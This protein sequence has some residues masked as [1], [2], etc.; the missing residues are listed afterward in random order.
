MIS[1]AN[2]RILVVA[3][4]PDDEVLGC[5]GTLAKSIA[6]GAEAS[7][8]LLGEGPTSRSN[9]SE[10]QAQSEAIRCAKAAAESLKIKTLSFGSLPDNQF[11]TVPLLNIVQQIEH[12]VEQIQ[13]DIVFTHHYGD[14]NIDHSLTHRATL[15]ALRPLPTTKPV[16]IL[17]FEVLSSTE[18]T[19]PNSLP[20]FTPNLYVDISQHLDAKKQALNEYAS[21]MR[22][23]P[24]PRSDIA[25][26]SL[27]K[28]R[29][30]QCG[31]EAAEAFILYRS[32]A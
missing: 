4:H 8:L 11:D 1:L 14:L 3:A 12:F 30:S 22:P 25:I 9:T 13:P 6:L 27:A 19:P 18:Y 15:T 2:K 20:H 16:S 7:I 31:Q 21:E 5:G 23:W 29:G 28:M 24:H 17:G 10:N 26:E 32:L